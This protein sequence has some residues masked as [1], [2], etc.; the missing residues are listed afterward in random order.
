MKI[1]KIGHCCLVI[2]TQGKTIM[3]DPGVYTE[4]QNSLLGVDIVLITHEHKDHLHIDS[5]KAVIKN[6]PQV[7][8]VTNSAVGKLLDTENIDYQ[9]LEN[10][11]SCTINKL[12]LESFGNTHAEIYKTIPRIQNTG[13]M[14]SGRFCYPGD[15]FEKPS[16]QPEIIA[17]PVVGPWMKIGEAVDYVLELKPKF[18]FPVHDGFLKFPGPFYAMPKSQLEPYGIEFI[19]PEETQEMEF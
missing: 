5:L 13:Y 15:A 8:V 19:T 14:I 16:N 7:V 17:L 6:N 2:K 4:V 9:I 12:S 10:R 3:T 1:K 11:Q 18:V